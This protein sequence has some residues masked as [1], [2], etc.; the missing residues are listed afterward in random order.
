M[1]KSACVSL[2]AL[3]LLVS[4][5]AVSPASAKS[6]AGQRAQVPFDYYVGDKLISAGDCA[7]TAVNADGS[8]LRISSTQ[9][10]ESAIVLTDTKLA[11]PGSKKSSRLVF[12]KYGDQYFLAA[13]WGADE[14]GRTLPESGRE[15]SL[16]RERQVAGNA[17][18]EVITI[19]AR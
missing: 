9:S 19:A 18:M 14:M 15:R 2:L 6:S 10:G 12:H 3:S 8:A 7:V 1:R 13:V 5:L 17:R 4:A 11:K 16:R